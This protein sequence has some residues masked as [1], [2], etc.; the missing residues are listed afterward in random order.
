M[1]DKAPDCG[2]RRSP[3]VG[4]G[5]LEGLRGEAGMVRR[6]R[7][8]ELETELDCLISLIWCYLLFSFRLFQGKRASRCEEG[9]C[10]T[11]WA[12][13]RRR[14]RGDTGKKAITTARQL[15]F[16]TGKKLQTGCWNKETANW[17]EEERE[18]K[19]HA[20][21]FFLCLTS[22]ERTWIG[23]AHTCVPW[24]LFFS[25][26]L[27]SAVVQVA[28]VPVSQSHGPPTRAGRCNPFLI[29]ETPTMS[30]AVSLLPIPTRSDVTDR[31]SRSPSFVTESSLA[32]KDPSC[33]LI[34]SLT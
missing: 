8:R 11:N 9:S 2:P 34:V 15:A 18:S 24:Q 28:S 13:K 4:V 23:A 30:Q 33:S 27:F 12:P 32:T 10:V 29:W 14:R 31:Y 25:C 26:M 7:N 22:S 5:E 16:R 6:W 19:I 3:S 1:S 17:E 20:V 21:W